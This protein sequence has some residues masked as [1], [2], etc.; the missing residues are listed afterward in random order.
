MTFWQWLYQL[1]HMAYTCDA[2]RV[3][4]SGTPGPDSA[5]NVYYVGNCVQAW[6]M[7][8][9]SPLTNFAGTPNVH[10]TAWGWIWSNLLGLA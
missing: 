5:G 8:V 1:Q 2:Y 4:W 3:G 10:S 6:V 9:T 7:S